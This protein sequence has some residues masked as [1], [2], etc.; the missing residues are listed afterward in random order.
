MATKKKS[1]GKL[2]IIIG[3]RGWVHVGNV[4]TET[5]TEVV[6][7]RARCVR[8]WGTKKGLAFL[9]GAGP[10]SETILDEPG[11]MRIHPLA[12]MH[13]YDCDEAAWRGKL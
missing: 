6:L 10:Q 3:H 11:T 7:E 8:R 2:Q 1:T 12:I 9:G 5:A 13:R 4:V